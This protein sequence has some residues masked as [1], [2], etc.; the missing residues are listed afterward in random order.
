MSKH[1]LLPVEELLWSWPTVCRTAKEN[2]ARGFALSIAK[3][4]KRRGWQPTPKQ[5]SLM[6][7]LVCEIYQRDSE[8]E[9]DLIEVDE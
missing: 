4:S 1:A 2:W 9:G 6:N 8:G 5:H 3:Q 7:R